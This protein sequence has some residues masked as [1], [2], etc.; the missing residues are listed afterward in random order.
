MQ[1]ER[2]TSRWSGSL[3]GLVSGCSLGMMALLVHIG[4]DVM[5]ATQLVFVRGALGLIIV[6]P[7]I[8][9]PTQSVF[10]WRSW[11]LWTRSVLGPVSVIAVF[12]N[13]QHT[14]VG[15]A[16]ALAVAGFALLPFVARHVNLERMP[17]RAYAGVVVVL[18][19]LLAL[20]LPAA[21]RPSTAVGVVG[22]GGAVAAALSSTAHRSAAQRFAPPLVVAGLSVG[23]MVLAC[24]AAFWDRSTS[25][26]WP[27]N[28]STWVLL[29]GVALTAALG[30]L[31][32]THANRR[33]PASAATAF[34]R[35]SLL[36]AVGLA[37][38]V[39]GDLPSLIEG[40]SYL[41]VF[42]GLVLI[43]RAFSVSTGDITFESMSATLKEAT[44]EKL[45]AMR[46]E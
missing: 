17:A 39:L 26:V 4:R 23:T 28:L 38:L 35:S 46:A 32:L 9:R 5:P 12:W 10:H 31:A 34:G 37:A 21:T 30:Q 13:L 27:S 19:G 44:G 16:G 14:S 41:L 2:P 43:A 22:V 1:P 20:T 40:L 6:A 29:V 42:T 24:T 33:L 3:L 36:W 8:T 45:H 18:G 7:F 15:T 25:W 11:G